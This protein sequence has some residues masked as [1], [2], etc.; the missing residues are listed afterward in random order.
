MRLD[1]GYCSTIEQHGTGLHC[2]R[3]LKHSSLVMFDMNT[4]NAKQL[5]VFPASD[6]AHMRKIGKV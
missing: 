2:S 3:F 6:P 1:M 4:P 5:N